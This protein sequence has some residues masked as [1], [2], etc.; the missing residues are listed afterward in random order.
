MNE[1]WHTKW[2]RLAVR[3]AVLLGISILTI[4]GLSVVRAKSARC[5]WCP[6]YTC[7]SGAAC[8]PRCSCVTIGGQIG[9]TCVSVERVHGR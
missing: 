8:G 2:R 4:A 7:Y 1:Y 6:S 5:A 9:G 3:L